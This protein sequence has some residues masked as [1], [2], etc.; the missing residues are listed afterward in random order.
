MFF[1]GSVLSG[2]CSSAEL[3]DCSP[4]M[5]FWFPVIPDSGEVIMTAAVNTLGE[6]GERPPAFILNY[7][8][9]L[10]ISKIKCA[11]NTWHKSFSSR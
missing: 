9:G 6:L 5:S 1:Q 10:C 3:L 11:G 2:L 4:L 8:F 7:F